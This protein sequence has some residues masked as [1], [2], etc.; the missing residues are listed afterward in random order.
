MKFTKKIAILLVV[1]LILGFN[2]YPRVKTR[3]AFSGNRPGIDKVAPDFSLTDLHGKKVRLSD[4]K[5][6]VVLVNFW[7]NWCPPCKVE[8]PGFQRVYETYKDKCFVII[9]ISVADVES[10]F[11]KD[12][13]ITYPVVVADDKVARDY[14][15]IMGIPVS[16]LIDKD[17]RVIKKIMGIYFED[18]LKSDVENALKS[19]SLVGDENCK[20]PCC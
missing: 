7:A 10:S 5:G 18:T 17:G 4:F 13:G 9:G 16:F 3:I 14:G 15:N 12:M 2:L 20:K 6:R 19:T 1:S 8:I 11:I